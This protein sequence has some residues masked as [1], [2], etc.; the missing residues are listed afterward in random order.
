MR[1]SEPTPSG[2]QCERWVAGRVAKVRP[3][4]STAATAPAAPAVCKKL[5]RLRLMSKG[6]YLSSR[7]STLKVRGRAPTPPGWAV[8]AQ[9]FAEAPFQIIRRANVEAAGSFASQDVHEGH[10]AE[11]EEW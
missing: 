6:A 10:V 11:R 5:R 8:S 9:V 1:A 7:H 4:T 3:G 2:C